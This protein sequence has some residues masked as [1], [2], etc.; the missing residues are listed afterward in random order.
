MSL[1]TLFFKFQT[2]SNCI[3]SLYIFSVCVWWPFLRG[4]QGIV[5]ACMV[6]FRI[7]TYWRSMGNV[8]SLNNQDQFKSHFRLSKPTYLLIWC[9]LLSVKSVWIRVRRRKLAVWIM[10]FVWITIPD[11]FVF[12]RMANFVKSH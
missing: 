9:D 3:I 8:P 11:G 6:L 7:I 10:E 1:L 5:E 4:W 12:V 2:S